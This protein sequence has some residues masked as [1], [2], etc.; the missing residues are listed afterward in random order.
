MSSYEETLVNITLDAAAG[1]AVNTAHTVP[2]GTASAVPAEASAAA[3]FQYRFVR[4]TGAHEC[5]VYTGATG[6]RVAG[7]LQ[8]KPQI[9]G[10]AATVAISG[11]S[12]IEASGAIA[13]GDGVGAG[14]GGRAIAGGTLGVA[15]HAAQE[16]GDL[17]P[18]LLRLPASVA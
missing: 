4:V 11:V 6:Q 8:N 2:R 12:L 17:I 14:A 3:G 9:E 7:V 13:A 18:V 1:L 10:H 16:A 5:D 15:I